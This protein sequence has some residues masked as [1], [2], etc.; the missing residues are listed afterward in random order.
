MD[1]IIVMIYFKELFAG[2]YNPV[3]IVPIVPDLYNDYVIAFREIHNDCDLPLIKDIL[4]HRLGA[5]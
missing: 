2:F 4:F 5:G 1:E 3:P